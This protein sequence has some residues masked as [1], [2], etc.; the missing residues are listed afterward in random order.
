MRE[1]LWGRRE[2][3][4]PLIAIPHVEDKFKRLFSFLLSYF[5]DIL[6]DGKAVNILTNLKPNIYTFQK[7]P[8]FNRLALGKCL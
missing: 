4:L 3:S 6:K 5:I 1:L 8:V 7:S 2:A